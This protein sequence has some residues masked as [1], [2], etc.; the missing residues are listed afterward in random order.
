MWARGKEHRTSNHYQTI[1]AAVAAVL[2]SILAAVDPGMTV[3][4]AAVDVD[5]VVAVAVAGAKPAAAV[6]EDPVPV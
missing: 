4:S 6:V 1:P 3:A 5:V 2:V